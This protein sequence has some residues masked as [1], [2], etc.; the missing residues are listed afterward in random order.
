MS[1]DVPMPLVVADAAFRA[2]EA[3]PHQWSTRPCGTCRL[4]TALLQRPFGC[5]ALRAGKCTRCGA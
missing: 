5:D 2:I 3:D 4:V 1:S